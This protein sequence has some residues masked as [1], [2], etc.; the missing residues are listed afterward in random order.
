MERHALIKKLFIT[1]FLVSA[2]SG[3]AVA[4]DITAVGD[5]LKVVVEN[6]G[7]KISWDSATGDASQMVLEGVKMGMVGAPGE[8]AVGKVTLSD[9]SEENGGYT[10]GSVTL[11]DYN[12]T[13]DDATIAISGME[14]AG[15]KL[16]APGSTDPL[17]N[18]MMYETADVANFTVTTGGK[19][20]FS[21]KGAHA[22]TTA[23]AEG[24]PM[25][26]TVSTEGWNADLSSVEDPQSKAVIEA[27][28]YQT[29]SG[30]VEM[31]GSW[32]PTDGR[33]TLS[34]YDI[35]VNDAGTLGMTFD[36]G[37]YTPDFIKSMQEMQ[38]KM[39]EQPAGAD[40]SAQ[41]LAM[42]G[43]MQQ[44]TFH[45]ASVRFD[46]DSLTGKALDF[47]AKAQGMKPQD[48]ANQAKALTPI[49]LA[50]VVQDQALIKSVSDAVTAFL[51]DPKSLE[52][53]AAPAQPVPFALI[54][55]GAMSAPQELPKTLGVTVTANQ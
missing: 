55:A 13:Q 9:I 42:L 1:T 27:M 26:F 18:L 37:G 5:R 46:D 34:S 28:G 29:I 38:K 8:F 3:W 6:Q 24:K 30:N 44:L 25:T 33:M 49:M 19:E 40:N 51:D 14:M 36:L 47:L 43:L 7:M 17:A 50:Q 32:Q 31:E 54:A 22:E 2:S 10:I 16:S 48:I 39:A 20:V 12:I 45:T 15:L 35:T 41:G 52:V 11:P 4:Q 21:M 53:T 23:P